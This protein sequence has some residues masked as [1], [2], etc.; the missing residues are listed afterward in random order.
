MP[1]PTYVEE[2]QEV[3][4]P[5]S[6]QGKDHVV[7]PGPGD[8]DHA[9]YG[10]RPHDKVDTGIPGGMAVI[11]PVSEVENDRKDG[12]EGEDD[13]PDPPFEGSDEDGLVLLDLQ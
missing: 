9:L 13:C 2:S 8:G 10:D 3:E 5:D 4:A 12:G 6:G 1:L 7:V 11:E